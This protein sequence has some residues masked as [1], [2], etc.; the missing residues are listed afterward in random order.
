MA[1]S[2]RS[3]SCYH[4]C[5]FADQEVQLHQQPK[6]Q[7][8]PDEAEDEEGLVTQIQQNAQLS[9]GHEGAD[10]VVQTDALQQADD[11]LDVGRASLV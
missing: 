2:E 9:G 5:P 4:Q 8:P 1:E 6:I 10:T 3:E 7:A 11:R